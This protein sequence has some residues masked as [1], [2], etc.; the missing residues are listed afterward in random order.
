MSRNVKFISVDYLKTNTT[1]QQNVDENILIPFILRA[2]EIYLQQLIGSALY[3]RLKDGVINNN[4][5]SNED[6]LLRQYI[7]PMISEYTFYLALPHI[8]YKLTNKAVS[9]ES[10]ENSNPSGLDEI[11][12]LRNSV[13]DMAQFYAKRLSKYLCD[14]DNLFPEYASADSD[15]N[16]LPNKKAYFNGVYLPRKKGSD[17]GFRSYNDPSKGDCC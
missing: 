14:N 5:N 9:Q 13:L 16:L 12:F 17:Y 8:N 4:L 2:Q 11:K 6:T 15:D 10:S 1:I 3:D 7:Q